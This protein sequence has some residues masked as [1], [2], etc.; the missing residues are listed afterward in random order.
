M[1]KPYE[2]RALKEMQKASEIVS[3]QYNEIMDHFLWVQ[4]LSITRWDF[5]NIMLKDYWL[6]AKWLL[7]LSSMIL[8]EEGR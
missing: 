1:E 8:K 4:N 7:K 5:K 2:K 6:R 3:K